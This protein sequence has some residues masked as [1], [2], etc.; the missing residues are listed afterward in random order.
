MIEAHTAIMLLHCW[1][2]VF[3]TIHMGYVEHEHILSPVAGHRF[4]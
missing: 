1:V 4:R 3:F 2:I